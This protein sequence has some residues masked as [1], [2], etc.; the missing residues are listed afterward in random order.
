MRRLTLIACLACAAAVGCNNNAARTA[1]KQ[2]LPNS[3]STSN[4][5][6]RVEK[7]DSG[8]PKP[9]NTAINKRDADG[10]TKTPLDQSNAKEDVDKTAE[11]RRRVVDLPDVSTNARNVKIVTGTD[12][13]VTLRGPVENAAE[14]D[15]IVK[16]AKEVAGDDKVDDQ[17]EV[18]VEK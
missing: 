15:A 3:S 8:P 18:K 10:D 6:A 13:K 2:N 17:I 1:N 16:I 5:D 11:I 9:D 14:H 7:N 4:S 12:G